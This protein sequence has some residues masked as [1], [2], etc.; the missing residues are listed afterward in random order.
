MATAKL[1]SSSV[2]GDLSFKL[3][4]M[5]GRTINATLSLYTKEGSPYKVLPPTSFT[6]YMI[7]PTQ[8]IT[9]ETEEI[10]AEGLGKYKVN[11]TP[12]VRGQHQL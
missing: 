7:C 5:T 9:C 11:A 10:D 8:A 12:S 1:Y 6:C 3:P 2:K 4:P